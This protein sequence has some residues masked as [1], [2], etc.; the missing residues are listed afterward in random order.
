MNKSKSPSPVPQKNMQE[1][2]YDK[3]NN[4]FM[5]VK[6][7]NAEANNGNVIKKNSRNYT[8]SNSP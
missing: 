5:N 8:L 6:F 2:E 3:M 4:I 7:V 1:Y